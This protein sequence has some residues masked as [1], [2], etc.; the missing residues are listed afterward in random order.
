MS[1]A[2]RTRVRVRTQQSRAAVREAEFDIIYG[3]GI[4]R[5]GELIDM[6][7]KLRSLSKIRLLV[8]LQG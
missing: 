1:S 4:S 7:S 5:T 6:A 8:Q 3:K 2:P